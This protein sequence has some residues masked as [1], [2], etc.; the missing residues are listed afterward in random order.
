MYVGC[1]SVAMAR[2]PTVNYRKGADGACD[3]EDCE[4][5]PLRNFML[6]GKDCEGCDQQQT[7]HFFPA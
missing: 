2:V 5:V 1:S 7:Q 4:Q 6:V 3:I